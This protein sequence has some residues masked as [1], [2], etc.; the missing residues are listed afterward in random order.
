MGLFDSLT[1]GGGFLTSMPILNAVQDTPLN[2]INGPLIKNAPAILDKAM[3]P[4]L[5]ASVLGMAGSAIGGPNSW[6]GRLGSGVQQAAN[7]SMMAG[8]LLEREKGQRDFLKK[9]LEAHGKVGLE[10]ASALGMQSPEQSGLSLSGAM[11]GK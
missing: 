4:M 6:Q 10:T 1:D 8:A 7:G 3:N 11:G 9:I 5:L 2:P